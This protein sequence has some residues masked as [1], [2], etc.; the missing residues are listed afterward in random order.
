MSLAPAL[1][2]LLPLPALPLALPL[3]FLLLRIACGGLCSCLC[4]RLL[5]PGGATLGPFTRTPTPILSPPP[6]FSLL[7]CALC[8]LCALQSLLWSLHSKPSFLLSLLLS[9]FLFSL[10]LPLLLLSL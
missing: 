3:A 1:L 8:A 7:L 9:F 2:P 6:L 10:L 4:G 5:P